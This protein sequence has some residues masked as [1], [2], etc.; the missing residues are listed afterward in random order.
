MRSFAMSLIAFVFLLIPAC[1][2][3]PAIRP[4]AGLMGRPGAEVCCRKDCLPFV[5]VPHR[6][7]HAIE[8][9]LPDGTITSALGIVLVDPREGSLHCVLMTPEGF[10]LLDAVDDRRLTTVQQGVPP[11]DQPAFAEGMMADIRLMLL[12]PMGKQRDA[13]LLKDNV[14]V[15]RYSDDEG[16]VTDVIARNGDSREIRQYDMSGFLRRSI[17]LSEARKH[18]IFGKIELDAPGFTGYSLRLTLLEAESLE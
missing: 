1:S 11:F 3:V 6:L 14:A 9:R 7:V 5:V 17:R 12:P 16:G 18:G 10:V 8:A 2:Q 4:D 15:C 13:G